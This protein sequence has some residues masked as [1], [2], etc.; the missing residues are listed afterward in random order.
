MAQLPF[1]IYEQRPPMSSA[2]FKALA[3]SL[4]E[5]DDA[6]LLSNIRLDP[7]AGDEGAHLTGCNFIDN[8]CTWERTLRLNLERN[9]AIKIKRDSLS[10]AEPPFYPADAAAVAQKAVNS[11]SSPLDTEIFIDKARWSA[12]DNL[13]GNDYFDRNNVYAYLLKLML[14][15]RRLLFNVER[16]FAE[17]KSLYASIIESAQNAG[18]HK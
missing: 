1:L 6:V 15:E 16:G 3:E 9:R 14:I 10:M 13:A 5:G 7:G 4:M 11:E 8:W 18:E 12:I 2:A 17:Y